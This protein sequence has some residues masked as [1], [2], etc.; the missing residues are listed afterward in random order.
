MT[1]DQLLLHDA[2]R[3]LRD[4]LLDVERDGRTWCTV[5]SN[6]IA[7]PAAGFER[8]APEGKKPKSLQRT[9]GHALGCRLKL[10]LDRM[11]DAT[12]VSGRKSA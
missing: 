4:E 3:L 1:T 5:C 8:F 12:D 7:D 9:D 10:L 11:D 2:G 6:V